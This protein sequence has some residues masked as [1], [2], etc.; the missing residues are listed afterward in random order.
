MY[1]PRAIRRRE[2]VN[3][4]QLSLWIYINCIIVFV[5]YNN[6][7]KIIMRIDISM[8]QKLLRR[9]CEHSSSLLKQKKT[10][11]INM[12][13]HAFI[14]SS[15]WASFSSRVVSC[16]LSKQ[17]NRDICL[18]LPFEDRA[19]GG[20]THRVLFLSVPLVPLLAESITHVYII[21]N[22]FL[23]PP[24]Q[25]AMYIYKSAKDEDI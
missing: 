21:H 7:C 18:H 11:R 10:G 3:L 1:N 22:F 25:A 12:P 19:R 15:M 8:K 16:M 20:N 2:R 4:N 17:K 9:G 23:Y 13:I 6:Q 24:V 5:Y 14:F